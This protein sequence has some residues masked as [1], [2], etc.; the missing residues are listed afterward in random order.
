MVCNIWTYCIIETFCTR[1]FALTANR[2]RQFQVRR[3]TFTAST[4]LATP[5]QP[6]ANLP[7]KQVNYGKF[8]KMAAAARSVFLSWCVFRTFWV[9]KWSFSCKKE[10]LIFFHFSFLRYDFEDILTVALAFESSSSDDSSDEDDLNLLLVD[11]MFPEISKPDY[12]RLNW[13]D[14]T[15]IQYE[16]M[17][18][19]VSLFFLFWTR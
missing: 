17:F 15:E 16:T 1:V 6:Q 4:A 18:R 10:I 11:A 7:R 14:L 13:E 8:Q 5:L 9:L 3:L 19:L 12:L 2:K